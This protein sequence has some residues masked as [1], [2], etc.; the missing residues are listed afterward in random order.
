MSDLALVELVPPDDDGP[1]GKR[2]LA[3]PRD[4]GLAAGLDVLGDGELALARKE[5]DRTHLAE[6][7]YVLS[8]SERIDLK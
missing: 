1:K 3:A 4:H 8:E 2:A 5:L 6:I 7:S